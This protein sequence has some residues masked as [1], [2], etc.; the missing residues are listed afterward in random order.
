M[1]AHRR[2]NTAFLPT[3]NARLIAFLPA[4]S[5]LLLALRDYRCNSICHPMI[6]ITNDSMTKS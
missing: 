3:F 1:T 5:H 6:K 4:Y 2:R